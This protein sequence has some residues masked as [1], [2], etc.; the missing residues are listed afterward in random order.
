MRSRVATP[1]GPAASRT[2][3]TIAWGPL[4]TRD[5]SQGSVTWLPLALVVASVVPPIDSVKVRGPAAAPSTQMSDHTTPLTVAP[6]GGLVMNTPLRTMRRR[7]VAPTS[8]TASRTVAVS[9]IAPF[10]IE[11]LSQGRVT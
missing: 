10:G 2:V 5:E 7:V 6:A 4:A 9:V 1:T 11:R 3:A 8:P